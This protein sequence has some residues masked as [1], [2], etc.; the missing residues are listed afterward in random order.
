[1]KK[2]SIG[3]CTLY[4]GSMEAVIPTIQFDHVFTD[5]P[6]LYLNKEF[7]KP[8]DEDILFQHTGSFGIACINTGRKYIGSEINK[9]YFGIALERIEQ[10]LS[11]PEVSN[12]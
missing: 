4:Q 9:G 11:V 5:P 2:V 6:Y 7:D 1:M 3:P 8:F 10:H 12:G